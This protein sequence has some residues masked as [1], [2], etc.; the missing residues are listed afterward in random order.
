VT[1]EEA[2]WARVNSLPAVAAIAST[3][4]YL[5]KLPQSPT[6]PCV[7]VQLVDDP[8]L[9]HVRGPQGSRRARVQVD[10]FVQEVSGVDPQAR[11]SALSA[12][13]DGDGLGRDASGLSGFIG[14]I[15]SPPFEIQG[16]FRVDRT[17]RYDPDELRVLT[18][19][20]DYM[21]T[22]RV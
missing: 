16:C 8:Q 20:Q 17:R 10:A 4:V 2:I 7:R 3:R 15:G 11:V 19:S 1:V 14:G 12:A 6:Y 5:E 13:I 21:V 9:Y 18:M 22:Y